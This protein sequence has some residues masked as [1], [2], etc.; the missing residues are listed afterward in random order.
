MYIMTETCMFL[1]ITT[2][3]HQLAAAAFV[4]STISVFTL[5]N[6]APTIYTHTTAFPPL[7]DTITTEF[8]IQA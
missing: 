4:A 1:N 2:A 6:K 3:K 7:W 5:V 8:M